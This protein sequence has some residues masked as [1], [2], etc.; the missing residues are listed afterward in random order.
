M[1]S[2]LI[3][4]APALA[5]STHVNANQRSTAFLKLH[6][7]RKHAARESGILRQLTLSKNKRQPFLSIPQTMWWSIITLCTI[8]YG[9][10]VPLSAPGKVVG[11]MC[12]VLG[13]NTCFSSCLPLVSPLPSRYRRPAPTTANM[14]HHLTT[15]C[16][17]GFQEW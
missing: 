15:L 10:F 13:E 5:P 3:P 12:C 14:T 17:S 9:D 1:R 8:G 4:P 16:F 7:T 11:S 6:R 2:P